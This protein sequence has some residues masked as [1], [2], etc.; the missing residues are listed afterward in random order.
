MDIAE[1]KMRELRM[2][3]HAMARAARHGLKLLSR[4]EPVARGSIWAVSILVIAVYAV[5]FF[6]QPGPSEVAPDVPSFSSDSLPTGRAQAAA[7]VP[8]I[9]TQL[10]QG[11][12]PYANVEGEAEGA[13]TTP[14]ITTE[15]ELAPTPASESSPL[16]PQISPLRSCASEGDLDCNCADFTTQAEAQAFFEEFLPADPHSM[17]VDKDGIACEWMG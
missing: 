11:Y 6:S 8:Q 2:L 13:L 1:R 9:D 3:C 10:E 16:A 7:D 14:T 12:P 4:A 5:T 17:D 15:R